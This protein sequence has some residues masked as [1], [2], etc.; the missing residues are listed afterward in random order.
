VAATGPTALIT[1]ISGQDGSF[2]AE[3][4]LAK[5]Y[6]VVGVVRRGSGDRG[7]GSSAHLAERV[8]TVEADLM[9]PDTIREAIERSRPSEIYHLAAP[10]FVPD[11]WRRP[12]DTLVAISGSTAAIIE[13]AR[14]HV[15]EARVLVAGSGQMFGDTAESPQREDSPCVPTNPYAVGKLA[16]HLLVGVMRERDGLH[17]SSAIMYNHESER[18]PERFVTRRISTAAAAISMGLESEITLGSLDAIRDWSFAGDFV[19]GMWMMLQQERAGDYILASGVGRTVEEL[20]RTA[21][22]CVGLDFDAHVRVDEA[23]VRKPERTASV[24]DP[25]KARAQLGWTPRVS[26]E[27]LVERMVRADVDRLSAAVRG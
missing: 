8:R 6:A 23:L 4:L 12:A 7:L 5:E 9:A 13:A 17:V 10:S 24:G 22:A 27:G 14:D 18:R 19:E 20:A 2:L 11:T 1:G 15:P 3:L 21:F 25:A 16:A 26:F